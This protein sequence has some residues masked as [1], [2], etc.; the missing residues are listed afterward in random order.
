M[1]L[2]GEDT[3][4]RLIEKKGGR[5]RDGYF[6]F[7][8][9]AYLSSRIPR[10]FVFRDNVC[11][12]DATAFERRRRDVTAAGTIDISPRLHVVSL[13]VKKRSTLVTDVCRMCARPATRGVSELTYEGL[14]VIRRTLNR[15]GNSFRN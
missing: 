6:I 1:R 4:Q 8:S 13:A 14:L 11:P 2:Q 15:L 7:V 5:K 3:I 12:L 9:R 10:D